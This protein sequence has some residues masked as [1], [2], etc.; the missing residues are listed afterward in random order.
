[1]PVVLEMLKRAE[2]RLLCSHGAHHPLVEALHE[3]RLS[4]LE[5]EKQELEQLQTQMADA[6][7]K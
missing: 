3:F 6:A 7:V 5:Q 2:Q 1:M 4:M